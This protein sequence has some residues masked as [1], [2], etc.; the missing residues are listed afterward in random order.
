MNIGIVVDNELNNDNRV[1]REISILKEHGY[2][3][4]VLCFGYSK[5]SAI[6]I[7][8]VNI[9][10]IRIPRKLKDALF[11]MLNTLPV[12]EWAWASHIKKFIKRN[13]VEALHV[14][15]LYMARSA[16]LGVSKSGR[17]IP[18]VLDLH[19]NY[20]FTVTTYNWTKGFLRS[21]ISRPSEWQKKER[22]YLSF[23]NRIIVLSSDFQDLLVSRYPELTA[24][25]FTVLPNVP[26][27]SVTGSKPVKQVK[28]PFQDGSPVILYYGVIAERRGV[29]DAMEVFTVL[30]KE[31]Y[32]VNFLLIGP[33]DNKDKHRFEKI[34]DQD[35]L[36]GKVYY[37]PWI[38]SAELYDYMDICDI[39]I[40]PFHKNPQ[41]ESGV[42]NKIYEYMLGEKPVVASDCRPQQMLIE[43]HNCGLIFRNN[44]EMKDAVLKLLSD[45][46]LR[47]E[48]G[49][50]GHEAVIRNYNTDLVKQDLIALYKSLEIAK[51]N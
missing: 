7:E 6:P 2:N 1:L 42:A 19:E 46:L 44:A 40:A 48:L 30:V 39:C 33:V 14:H 9:T 5:I 3:V 20:P 38:N 25:I 18:L 13:N 37:I 24:A 36:K 31:N 26:D 17:K 49:R 50:N 4:F 21:R 23:A 8:G 12:Y 27:I 10:R 28:N 34:L 47:K 51:Q 15:D 11:F 29:F 41:H 43:K 45:P 32:Q 22:K 35:L 16:H